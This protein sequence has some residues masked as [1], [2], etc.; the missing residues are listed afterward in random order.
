M[1]P[2][3]TMRCHTSSGMRCWRTILPLALNSSTRFDTSLLVAATVPAQLGSCTCR[4][5]SS[6]LMSASTSRSTSNSGLY[7]PD[8]GS[9]RPPSLSTLNIGSRCAG[10]PRMR[11]CQM[12]GG[13]GS[14]SVSDSSGS[15]SSISIGKRKRCVSSR[16]AVTRTFTRSCGMSDTSGSTCGPVMYSRSRSFMPKRSWKSKPGSLN[17]MRHQS[18]VLT[19][20]QPKYSAPMSTNRPV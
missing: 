7:A 12:S 14:C 17:S 11:E 10:S 6:V 3:L 5:A 16:M 18:S 9:M 19:Y 8:E 20:C 13:A 2:S 4:R 15:R 1:S